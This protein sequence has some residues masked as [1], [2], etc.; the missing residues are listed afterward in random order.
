[1]KALL[2]SLIFLTLGMSLG[3]QA[4]DSEC[5]EWVKERS[6]SC[7]FGGRSADVYKRKCENHCWYN[8]QTRRGNMGPDC[9]RQRAC[10]NNNPT[11][12]TS[13]CSEWVKHS[14]VT[15]H[16]SETDSWEQKWIRVCTKGY[17]ERRC[18]G[19]NPNRD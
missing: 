6:I 19:T 7:I 8:S 16:S 13:V 4:N 1:M 10:T 9:N 12:F 18:S 14:G 11:N 5:T 2:L 17:N 15:C 3:L